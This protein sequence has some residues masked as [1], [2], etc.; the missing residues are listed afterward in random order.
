M[1]VFTLEELLKK[2]LQYITGQS[3]RDKERP[4]VFWG[5]GSRADDH[6]QRSR[7]RKSLIF[8]NSFFKPEAR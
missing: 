1:K 3:S 4:K 2:P 5:T 7:A 8:L 6:I